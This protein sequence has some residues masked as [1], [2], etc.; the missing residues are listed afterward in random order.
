MYCSKATCEEQTVASAARF[1]L[2]ITEDLDQIHNTCVGKEPS[3]RWVP[4]EPPC[5]LCTFHPKQFGMSPYCARGIV[6]AHLG[7][8]PHIYLRRWILLSPVS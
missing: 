7:V 4:L 2:F 5:V 6:C 3:S 8:V 1:L